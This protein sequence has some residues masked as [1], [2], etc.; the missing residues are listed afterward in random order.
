MPASSRVQQMEKS[1][2]VMAEPCFEAT[3]RTVL[4]L[5]KQSKVSLCHLGWSTAAQSQLTASSTSQAQAILPLSPLGSWDYRRKPPFLRWGFTMFPRLVL[6]SW[7]QEVHLL[8]FPKN[9]QIS[10]TKRNANPGLGM[11]AHTC[12]P[13]TLE[14][15]SGHIT[16]GREFETHLANMVNPNLY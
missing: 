16:W 3:T 15:Q 12:N 9:R 7:A 13:S 11:V 1:P 2:R 4:L 10:E 6:N 5:S 8:Q 14:G